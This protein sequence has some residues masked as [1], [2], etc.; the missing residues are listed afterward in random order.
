MAKNEIKLGHGYEQINLNSVIDNIQQSEKWWSQLQEMMAS[1]R[2]Q[3][4]NSF[5]DYAI[6]LYNELEAAS[7]NLTAQLP[8]SPQEA[9]KIKALWVISAP[10]TY[11]KA[12]K[13]DRYADKQWA[14]WNDRQRI[15]RAF[16]IGRYITELVSEETLSDNWAKVRESINEYG[17]FIIYNGRPDENEALSQAMKAP[18]L[19]LPSPRIYSAEKVFII[20][21]GVD[22]TVDNI[23]SFHLPMSVSIN[24]GDEIGIV[25]HA[26]QAV[27]FLFMLNQLKVSFPDNVI[28]RIFPLP[29]PANGIPEYPL[30]ELRGL[31]YNRFIVN[32]PLAATTPYPYTV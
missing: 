22:N 12:K 8:Q 21:A 17:P 16:S 4:V 31:I 2:G 20:N 6:Q 29:T 24:P 10:G 28:A 1:E 5:I 9:R 15:N 27:R 14:L 26:P 32:P 25:I 30:Q 19:F 13:K 23:K 7:Y 3:E 18:W 11:F